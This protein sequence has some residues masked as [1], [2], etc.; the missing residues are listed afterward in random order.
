MHYYLPNFVNKMWQNSILYQWLKYIQRN[1]LF[2]EIFLTFNQQMAWNKYDRYTSNQ[3][4]KTLTKSICSALRNDL[5]RKY[6]EEVLFEKDISKSW[7]F[8]IRCKSSV[9]LQMSIKGAQKWPDLYSYEVN[10]SQP[11]RST[12]IIESFTPQNWW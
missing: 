9:K 3:F 1:Y 8:R 5:K 6:L 12:G 11:L 2:G 4:V 7:I 10:I